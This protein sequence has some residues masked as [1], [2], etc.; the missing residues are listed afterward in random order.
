[1]EDLQRLIARAA[2]GIINWAEIEAALSSFAHPMAQTQ[3][4]PAYHGEGDVWTHTKLVC[5]ELVKL[6][7]YRAL[8]TARR[9]LL[10]LAALLHDIGKISTTRW[11]EGTW[12]SPNHA[13]AGSKL[14]RRFLWEAYS[15]MPEKL[16]V[17]ETVCSLI[18]FH[19]FPPHALA[20]PEGRQK[21][22]AI[23][24]N[25]AQ[26]PLFTLHLL[27]LLCE[28]DAKGRICQDREELAE[29][30]LF[31]RE[32][33]KESGC[34]MAPFPFPSDYTRYAYLS[35]RDIVP[36]LELYDD[37][38]G[39]VILLSGLPGTGKDTWISTNC[40]ELPVISLDDVR[41]VHHISPTENQ[42][43]VV[44]IAKQQ[45]KEYLRKKQSFVWNATDLSPMVR[46][47]QIQLF[48]QYH[49]RVRL[50]Y[51]ETDWRECLRRN[52]SRRDAVPEAAVCHML[53]DLIPP[54]AKEAH[55]VEWHCV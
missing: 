8:P 38:W 22:M 21:L 28:A 55:R 39:E 11:E 3:Q 46:G 48:I 20:D 42:R 16:W 19:S 13:L 43:R 12:I 53:E 41:K 10:L 1:M 27:C 34:L 33:A 47:A 32:L 51:L 25:G 35:G 54:E 31:C 23:A 36:E 29:N 37:T 18:R 24:A 52:A 7:A 30:I 26:C 40:P 9:Q 5:E 15:G 49:A 44:D 14:A 4:N 17:R 50:V 45:A 6:D 2:D